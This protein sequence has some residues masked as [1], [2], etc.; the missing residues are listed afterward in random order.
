LDRLAF[1]AEDVGQLLG[2]NSK[3]IQHLI[4]SGKIPSV[5]IAEGAPRLRRGDLVDWLD[6]LEPVAPKGTRETL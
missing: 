1:A 3:V 6:K 5:R 2:I 4:D